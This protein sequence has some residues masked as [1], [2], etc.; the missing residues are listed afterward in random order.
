[1]RRSRSFRRPAD[2]LESRR[3]LIRSSAG[4]ERDLEDE[5]FI[6]HAAPKKP[7]GVLK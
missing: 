3:S 1:M 6:K 4:R 5:A 2:L 7:T